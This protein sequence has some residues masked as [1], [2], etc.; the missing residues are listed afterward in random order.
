MRLINREFTVQVP[1]DSAWDHFLLVE[2]WPSWAGHIRSVNLTPPGPLGP[3]TS[4]VLKLSNGVTSVFEVT[5]FN[6]HRNWKWRGPFL[7][8]TLDYDHRFESISSDA[9]RFIW[10]IDAAGSLAGSIG[11]VF[12]WQYNRNL[13]RAIPRQQQEMVAL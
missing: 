8:L 12:A 6:L 3:T 4:G 9:T 11:R 10:T 1:L 7:W 2:Q 5:E 13:D